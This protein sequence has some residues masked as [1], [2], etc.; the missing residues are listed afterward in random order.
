MRRV[1]REGFVLISGCGQPQNSGNDFAVG[2]KYQHKRNGSNQ[3][4]YYIDRELMHR[5]VSTGKLQNWRD[6]REEVVNFV[7]MTEVQR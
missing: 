3:E 7:R 6:V 5:S 4:N 2:G 1:C